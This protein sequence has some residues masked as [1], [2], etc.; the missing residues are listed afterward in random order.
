MSGLFLTSGFALPMAAWGLPAFGVNFAPGGVLV[1]SAIKDKG[2]AV[3]SAI[4][5]HNNP[6]VPGLGRRASSAL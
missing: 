4:D 1:P 3:P 2:Y 5:P 6:C